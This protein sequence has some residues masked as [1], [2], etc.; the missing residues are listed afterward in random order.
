M[1]S[2]EKPAGE[3]CSLEEIRQT[4]V[5]AAYV[6]ERYGVRYAPLLDRIER[7]YEAALARG[8]PRERARRILAAHS[9]DGDLKAIR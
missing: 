4:L 5:T 7:E 1:S 8:D 6:V 9:R 3:D 2:R